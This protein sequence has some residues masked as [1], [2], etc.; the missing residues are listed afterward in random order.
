M[1][2]KCIVRLDHI[3]T[4]SFTLRIHTFHLYNLLDLWNLL[5]LQSIFVAIEVKYGL[6]K[7]DNI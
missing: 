2:R 1:Y 3:T 5:V 7:Q 4:V 6:V